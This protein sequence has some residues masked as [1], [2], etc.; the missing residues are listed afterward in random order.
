VIGRTEI[1]YRRQRRIGG[2]W[3]PWAWQIPLIVHCRPR[4]VQR[5]S[6]HPTG[7]EVIGRTEIFLQKVT[8]ATKGERVVRDHGP[9]R[10]RTSF[11]VALAVCKEMAC[12]QR[13]QKRSE[14]RRL[15]YGRQRR[16]R[17]VGGLLGSMGLADSTH[18]PLSP[19]RCAR[20]SV[21][22][23]G[24]E[25]IGRTETFFTEG[26]GGNEGLEGC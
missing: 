23:T 21:C 25:A 3:G 2:C 5:N 16:Q 6:A 8:K 19:S 22:P 4:G 1:F 15:F 9:S 17:R 14:G 26:N 13:E 11:I 18:R 24:T 20:N 10:F 12:V 7:T